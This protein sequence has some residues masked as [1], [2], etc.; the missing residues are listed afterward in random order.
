MPDE[1]GEKSHDPTP[2][3]REQAR[4]EGQVAKSQDLASAL[5]LLIAIILLLTQSRTI[6]VAFYE[7][8][9]DNIT[10]D[11]WLATDQYTIL[12]YIITGIF[13]FLYLFLLFGLVLII[14]AILVNLAQVGI[15]WLP[16]KL[17]FDFSRL[18]PIK[19][20]GRIFSM[21]SV[22]RLGM[23]IFKIIICTIVAFFAVAG[24]IQSIMG[25][26]ELTEGQ[27]SG[28]MVELIL[29]IALK[30]TVALVILAILDYIYQKWKY[31]QDLKMTT[32]EIREEMKNTLGNPEIM[33][34]R[35]QIQ[36]EMAQ[37][38]M[39]QA[40]PNADVVVTNP[41][42]LAVA[43]KYDPENMSAPIVVAKGAGLLAQ[44][45]RRIALEH[46][47]PI[48]ERKPLARALYQSVEV[49]QPIPVEQYSAVAEV[50]AYVYQL[51]G[52]K[53]PNRKNQGPQQA[54]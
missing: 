47:I 53:A 2:R 3:R 9:L 32:Q 29:W 33:Q 5:I 40:V 25:L 12:N 10:G 7:Y 48:I 37:Q 4:E 6:G 51:Q 13:K 34:R 22:M 46:G 49:D 11:I 45:I 27:I 1:G 20:F 39:G 15:L 24:D 8:T 41:T 30:M 23:G 14:G 44:R 43:L 19:G 17:G 18:D 28:Y 36:R 38:R 54:A 26:T 16:N 35:R 31:E 52:K 21:Q 50:L 42:E